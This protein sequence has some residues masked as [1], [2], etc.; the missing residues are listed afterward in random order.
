MYQNRN[1]IPKFNSVNFPELGADLDPSREFPSLSGAPQQQG[2]PQ[3]SSQAQSL[4][5][6]SSLRATQH[7]PVQRPQPNQG[8]Q[9]QASQVAPGQQHD[10]R[11]EG[12]PFGQGGGED[13]HF[14]AP[15]GVGQLPGMS[16]PQTGNIEEFPPLGGLGNGAEAQQDRRAAGM[17]QNAT[18]GAGTAASQAGR[19]P[20]GLGQSRASLMSPEANQDRRLGLGGDRIPSGEN[21]RNG[22]SQQARSGFMAQHPIGQQLGQAPG[23]GGGDGTHESIQPP[24]Q[25]LSS[26]RKRIADMTPMEKWGIP[27][28]LAQIPTESPD[29]NPL[30]VGQDLTILGLDLNRPDNSPLYPTV[31]TVFDDPAGNPA[32]P[33]IPDYH[34]PPS[35]IVSN[36]PPLHSKMA[37]FSDETLFTIFYTQT[38]DMMQELAAAELFARDWRWHKELRQWMQKDQTLP[39]PRPLNAKMEQGYYIFFDV[40]TWSRQRVWLLHFYLHLTDTKLQRELQL[41]YD[42][43]DQ[44]HGNSVSHG[45]SL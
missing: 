15:G 22:A 39:P 32:A 2:Q 37:N 44:R 45:L 6:N 29:H 38:R 31:G 11:E 17:M 13:Y 12:P 36:V 1:A 23:F 7:T 30:A 21:G 14:G 18:F 28:L 27:G 41:H 20:I 4:W 25:S 19:F 43:L 9:Q 33:V 24:A 16:Q 26:N 8:A 3:Q 42:A 10:A 35:Y 40:Q 5:A 34:N